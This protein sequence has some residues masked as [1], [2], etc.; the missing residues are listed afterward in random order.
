MGL[1]VKGQ[2]ASLITRKTRRIKT[3][4]SF[5]ERMEGA[6]G[7]QTSPLT[8]A[9]HSAFTLGEQDSSVTEGTRR[10]HPSGRPRFSLR[11][12]V[13]RV[14]CKESEKCSG[15]G[16]EGYKER[17]SQRVQRKSKEFGGR[18]RGISNREREEDKEG[19]RTPSDD[20]PFP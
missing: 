5:Y 2:K 17:G 4:L 20:L 19:K 9:Q 14:F 6:V 12:K 3:S 16:G 13:E 7:R 15:E 18:K 8:I 1:E 10:S 11:Q